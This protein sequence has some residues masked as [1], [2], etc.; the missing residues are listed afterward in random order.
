MTNESNPSPSDLAR[1]IRSH[2]LRMVAKA[3]ASHVGTCL[4]MADLLAGLYGEALRHDPARPDWSERDR[5]LLSKGHGAAILYAVLAERGFFP[6]DWLDHYCED[7]SPLTGHASHRVPGIE[8]STGSLGHGL[9]VGCGLALAAKRDQHNHR[10]F[11]LM[12]DGELDEGSN[13]EA[14]LFA[15]HHR[16]DNLVAI[17]DY[18]KIQSFGSVKEVL[19]LDPLAAKFRAFNWAV[20]EIDGH[21]SVVID[22]TLSAVPFERG[23][24]SVIVAH[25][26]KG[27]GVGYMQDQLAWHYNSPDSTQL[28]TALAEVAQGQ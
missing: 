6:K 19:D 15:P 18:N 3:K 22:K 20:R 10:V 4:S 28:A 12:S 13:W 8:L 21:D 14:I 7:G 17:I 26:V 27:K 2:A 9:P 23:H 1:A 24:P 16:L 5:F 25:T 11:V